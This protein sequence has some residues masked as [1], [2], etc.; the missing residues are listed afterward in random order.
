MHILVSLYIHTLNFI[1][2]YFETYKG[3]Y[4]HLRFSYCSVHVW[5]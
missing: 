1:Y 5:T 3:L 2:V 4:N